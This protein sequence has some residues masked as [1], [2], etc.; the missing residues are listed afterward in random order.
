[1]MLKDY[2]SLFNG[3]E[4]TR[5][6]ALAGKVQHI[7][8][9]LASPHPDPL[10]Q[11]GRDAKQLSSVTLERD[12]AETV[13]TY[14]S[15]CH[16]RAAGVSKAPRDVLSRL[17][18]MRYVEMAD[19]DRCAGGAGT[20]IVKNFDLSQQIF[21]RKRRGIAASGATVVATSCPACMIRLRAGL[22]DGVR[23]AHVAQ[24]ADEAER[25]R[26]TPRAD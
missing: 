24:L 17:P 20:F 23:V 6:R 11:G 5:A 21:E 13:V 26:P 22:S 10:P 25:A 3:G 16:L 9:V 4:H 14:H 19:A 18:G 1:M 15:S 7:T 8:E 12:G 2:P